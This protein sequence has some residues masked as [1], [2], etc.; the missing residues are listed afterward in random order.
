MCDE[1]TRITPRTE[2][3]AARIRPAELLIY[4]ERL[5]KRIFDILLAGFGLFISSW[6][7]VLII[8]AIIIE[9]GFPVI[10]R[11]KR[12]GKGGAL[13]N[14]FKFRSMIKASLN[15]KVQVQAAEND[16]RVTRAGKILRKTALDELPQ[17]LNILFGEMSF[18]GPRPLLPSESEINGNPQII[19]IACIP[20]YDKR[21]LIRPG[22]T[23][24]SQVFAS[25]DLPR[26][27]KFKYD[28]LYIRKAGIVYDIRL[29]ISSFL[30]TFKGAWEKRCTKLR[31]LETRNNHDHYL[32]SN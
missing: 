7:W 14:S 27:H 22:L 26:R 24:I 25:R 18:V 6:L 23:G 3:K 29:I 8:T 15:E 21:I 17:L 13:F 20:G 19:N 10:I 16:H 11:Q 12:I 4:H 31:F 1:W 28:I 30:V 2:E 5:S 9:D 32:T